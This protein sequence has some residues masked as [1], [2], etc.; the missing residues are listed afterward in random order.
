MSLRSH[1]GRLAADR[2]LRSE[3]ADLPPW[4]TRRWAILAC[5]D[6]RLALE[7]TLGLRPGDAHGLRPG[8]AHVIRNAGGLVTADALR[9]LLISS[10]VLG[11][12]EIAVIEHT[13]CGML[14]LDEAA[15]GRLIAE[16]TGSD[17]SGLELL[18]FRDL[19]ANLRAQVDRLAACLLLPSEIP[20]TGFVYEVETGRLR[21][22]A[23]AYTGMDLAT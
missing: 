15:T 7:L 6:A 10:Q 14:T 1:I 9:S 18:S 4:P 8:D 17:L 20:V 11:T 13:D 12:R 2:S 21:E 16:R 22:I 3:L 23:S 19:E 5:M